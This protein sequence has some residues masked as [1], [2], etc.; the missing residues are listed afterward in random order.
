[1][2]FDSPPAERYAYGP[3]SYRRIGLYS[4]WPDYHTCPSCGH[5]STDHEAQD[6]RSAVYYQ[7]NPNDPSRGTMDFQRHWALIGCKICRKWCG[8]AGDEPI[9]AG[10]RKVVM[11]SSG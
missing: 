9:R 2:S 3:N 6:Q 7:I 11:V 1:M 4:E 10:D 8:W 5:E